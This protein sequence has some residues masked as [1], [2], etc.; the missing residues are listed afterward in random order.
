MVSL[1]HLVFRKATAEVYLRESER[2]S[3]ASRE[4]AIL[5]MSTAEVGRVTIGNIPVGI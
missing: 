1:I 5:V 2:Q 4:K 3:L